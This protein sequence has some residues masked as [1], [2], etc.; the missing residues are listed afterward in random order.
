MSR[1]FLLILTLGWSAMFAQTAPD[2]A[3][4]FKE[5]G[6]NAELVFRNVYRASIEAYAMDS[7]DVRLPG[8]PR[9]FCLA[10]SLITGRREAKI[11]PNGTIDALPSPDGPSVI[12]IAVLYDDGTWAGNPDVL[13]QILRARIAVRSSIPFADRT[14]RDLAARAATLPDLIWDVERWRNRLTDG[15]FSTF[16]SG[17]VVTPAELRNDRIRGVYD[18]VGL[19]ILLNRVIGALK[20]NTANG[21]TPSLSE[22]IDRVDQILKET[23]AMLSRTPIEVR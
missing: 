10:D 14:F 21:E 4:E 13:R 3:T 15:D 11:K 23:E 2:L 8:Q 20:A 1:F 16:V 18:S 17:G 5:V 6:G 22:A 19:S 12:R 7:A 9:V